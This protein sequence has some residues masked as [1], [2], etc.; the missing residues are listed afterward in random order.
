MTQAVLPLRRATLGDLDFMVATDLLVDVE[1]APDEPPYEAG[2]DEGERASH[3]AKIAAYV[4]DADKAAWVVHATTAGRPVGLVM[5]WFRDRRAEAHTEANDF[6]FR[7]IDEAILPPDGRF[8]EVFQ[9]WVDPA[10]RRR[11]LATALKQQLEHE[12]RA[13]GISMIYTHT[14]ERNA[15]VLDLNCKLGYVEIRRGPLW[16]DAP[17]VSLV[18]RLA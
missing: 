17:R 5:A 6:L 9:L 12:C 16:D 3:R 1:D 18:K 15:G 10:Y 7:F 14:R 4:T 13:R 8:C 11:G 2:M